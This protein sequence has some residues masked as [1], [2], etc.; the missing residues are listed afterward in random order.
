MRKGYNRIKFRDLAF[1]L[2]NAKADDKRIILIK[3]IK[4]MEKEKDK[5]ERESMKKT[6]EANI[7]IHNL[8]IGVYHSYGFNEYCTSPTMATNR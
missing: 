7:I 3:M 4:M 8:L 6:I 1:D 5:A 2:Q